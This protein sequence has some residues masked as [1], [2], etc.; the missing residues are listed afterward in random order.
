MYSCQD[1]GQVCFWATPEATSQPRALPCCFCNLTGLECRSAYFLS[2]SCG[3]TASWPPRLLWSVSRR[4]PVVTGEQSDT[5]G[6]HA[7]S[8]APS[9]TCVAGAGERELPLR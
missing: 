4:T 2:E 3:I 6:G 8:S 1:E 7:L 9:I 5:V